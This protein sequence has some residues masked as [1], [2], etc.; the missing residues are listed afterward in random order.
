MRRLE[1]NLKRMIGAALAACLVLGALPAQAAG[2]KR[3][4]D[5][6][7]QDWFYSFVEE[8][9]GQGIVSGYPD[10]SFQPQKNVTVGEV[11]SLVMIATGHGVQTKTG[12]HWSSGFADY[13]LRSG[14]LTAG[15]EQ[16]LDAEMK[17]LEVAQLVAKAMKLVP[18][19]GT[20]SAFVD[21]EDGYVNI[22]YQKGILAGS[23][24][25]GNRVFK[26]DD[27]IT[28]AEISAIIWNI[29]N[30]DVY[31]G[32]IETEYYYVDVLTEVP[33]SSY[34][35]ACFTV[36]DGRVEY[37]HPDVET[38]LGV[39][40]ASFQGN[41]DWKKVKA[42]G[43]DFAIIRIGGRGYTEGA[44]YEDKN[45]DVNI[46]GA[47]EAGL[48]VGAYFF[49]QAVNEA[50]AL[51]EAEF[52]LEKLKPYKADIT[53]PVVF[54]WEDF[55]TANYRT[56][57]LDSGT[58]GSCASLFCG[59]MEDEGYQPMIYFNRYGAY[60]SYDLRHVQKYPFWFAQ[61][62]SSTQVPTLYY[63][64]AM[65]QF[66]DKGIVDGIPAEVDLNLYFI[67]E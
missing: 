38:M 66:S 45:F 35:P 40:V 13:A 50:E 55:G 47:L 52:V 51:E 39:D 63:D 58:L 15:L 26:P 16:D 7:E 25:G 5:V 60:R 53:F 1:R 54:D 59:M 21:T 31:A 43:I 18:P 23:L 67:K 62:L 28:R 33:V 34:D 20:A 10:G 30:T 17:R 32:M 19:K 57:R 41:I 65:W 3:F 44:L 11:L 46:Q 27:P 8:L 42:D 37:H 56:Y 24:E 6:K 61:Y 22:L 14:Y 36:K 2:S 49:S 9:S 29:R 12:A 64:F 48:E 4:S